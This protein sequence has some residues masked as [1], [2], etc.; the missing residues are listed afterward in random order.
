MILKKNFCELIGHLCFFI[1]KKKKQTILCVYVSAC[2]WLHECVTSGAHGVQKR[3]QDLLGLEL[4]LIVS[5]P[6]WVLGI[7]LGF[8]GEEPCV[9][10]TAEP[11][12]QHLI[13]CLLDLF[14]SLP[15][16]SLLFVFIVL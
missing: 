5:H 2:V 14:K 3:A 15:F 7:K 11:L 13:L 10:F 1:F 16:E 8:S 4:Q 6:K 12:L 9:F